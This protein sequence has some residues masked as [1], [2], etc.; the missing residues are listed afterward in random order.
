MY[1]GK[2]DDYEGGK[3]VSRTIDNAQK[4]FDEN[5]EVK[6]GGWSK[7]PLF[8]YNKEAYPAPNK[9][10]EKDCYYMSN[11]E[12]GFYFSVET[13]GS[14][15]MIKLVF[16]DFKTRMVHGLL[17]AVND[18]AK[19]MSDPKQKSPIILRNTKQTSSL[20]PDRT[21]MSELLRKKEIEL[22]KILRQCSLLEKSKVSLTD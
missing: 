5:G 2:N 14:E 8:E 6:I 3:T 18:M 4:I 22:E 20:R 16:V 9:L 17:R 12:M 19:E 11:G 7:S 1:N 13:V 21:R 10:V 15:L